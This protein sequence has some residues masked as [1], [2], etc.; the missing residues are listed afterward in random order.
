MPKPFRP[1]STSGIGQKKLHPPAAGN[2][3]TDKTRG[4]SRRL[5]P[6]GPADGENSNRERDPAGGKAPPKGSGVNGDSVTRD[7]GAAELDWIFAP[8]A[9]DDRQK[10]GVSIPERL[11]DATTAEFART[12]A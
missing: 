6:E 7:P 4:A 11:T 2:G 9:D 10:N 1:T 3:G 8:G 12:I 5:A